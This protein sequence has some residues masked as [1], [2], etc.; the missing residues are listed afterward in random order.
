LSFPSNGAVISHPDL[1]WTAVSGA[2]EYTVELAQDRRFANKPV[3][4][5]TSATRYIPQS[6]L[7]ASAYWW[8][9]RV[10]KPFVSQWSSKRHFNRRWLVPD[11]ATG[12]QEV[13]RPDNVTIEDFSSTPGM[14]A[15]INA[16]QIRWEPVAEAAYYVVQF[17]FV[18]DAGPDLLPPYNAQENFEPA[19][20]VCVTPHTVLTPNISRADLPEQGVSLIADP[21]SQ[22][23]S[24]SRQGLWAVRVRAVD[25]TTAGTEIFSLWSDEARSPNQA[26]PGATQFL[27]AKRLPEDSTRTPAV[28]TAPANG[29]TFTDAPVLAWNPKAIGGPSS[30]SPDPNNPTYKVVIALDADFTTEVGHFW[31]T[32]TRFVPTERFPE[33]NARQAYYWYVVPCDENGYCVSANQVVN[34]P[35]VYRT[36]VKLSPRPQTRRADR[37]S[38]PFTMFGW[39]SAARTARKLS[40][41]SDSIA[42]TDFYEF[43][44]RLPGRPW[45]DETSLSDVPSY[46]P[47]DLLFNSRYHWRVR[48]VD[49][50]GQPRP[51]SAA[52]W[53]RTPAAA[54]ASPPRLRAQ[55]RNGRV[56]LTW[57]TPASRYFPVDSYSIFYSLNGKRWKPLGNTG[58][59]RAAYRVQN[60][61]RYWFMVT[62][63]SR[64]G[65]SMPSRVVVGK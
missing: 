18:K 5:I 9:V 15:P 2:A 60:K 25:V 59:R 8:R 36:F 21:R 55:R 48:V 33:D 61:T 19:D 14:Q 29:S 45:S 23:C 54:P 32:N 35:S 12:R 30:Q 31:T 65:A 52:R 51:W 49:G 3:T 64:G 39:V 44:K 47:S 4:W 62:A 40:Q 28:L 20:A 22:V 56:T 50:S 16:L 11:A 41:A 17:D 1:R 63:N 7:P 26:A 38:G 43:Q 6:T 57:G 13:A 37:V 58:G 53:V 34:R 10:S 27:L 42:G 24:V 46:L